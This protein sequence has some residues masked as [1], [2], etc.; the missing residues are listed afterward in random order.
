MLGESGPMLVHNCTQSTAREILAHN[1]P[2]VEENGFP[3]I[4]QVHDEVVTEPLDELNFSV[5]RLIEL[6]TRRPDWVDDNLPL[7]AG[8]FEAYRYK[9]D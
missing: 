3:I 6:L 2:H 9:K 4:L 7:A 5:Q 8:G 1:L